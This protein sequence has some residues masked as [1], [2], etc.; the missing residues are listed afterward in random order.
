MAIDAGI[1]LKVVVAGIE[2]EQRCALATTHVGDIGQALAHVVGQRDISALKLAPHQLRAV[3]LAAILADLVD[4]RVAIHLDDAAARLQEHIAGGAAA[5][6]HDGLV[7]DIITDD[8]DGV[9]A[10]AQVMDLDVLMVE[11]VV[12][13]NIAVDDLIVLDIDVAVLV[14]RVKTDVDAAGGHLVDMEL[15]VTQMKIACHAL[16]ASLLVVGKQREHHAAVG[17]G[18]L[19]VLAVVTAVVELV[20]LNE[21]VGA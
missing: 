16:V 17:L 5:V 6:E 2:L 11:S 9:A 14:G 13:G 18:V 10:A 8:T 21:D 20:V 7:A 15:V 4:N 19:L 12:T 3:G 1:A